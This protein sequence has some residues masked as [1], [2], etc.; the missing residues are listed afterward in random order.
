MAIELY[1][2]GYVAIRKDRITNV[3]WIDTDTFAGDIKRSKS[4]MQL[5]EK[6][7]PDLAKVSPVIGYFLARL[8]VSLPDEL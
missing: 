5:D 1:E 3:L 6:R 7:I 2:S 4:K 8:Q